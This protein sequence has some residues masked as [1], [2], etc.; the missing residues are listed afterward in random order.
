MCVYSVLESECVCVYNLYIECFCVCVN[1]KC[2]WEC[3]S[4]CVRAHDHV[5]QEEDYA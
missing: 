4:T 5:R 1:V 2:T 3:V